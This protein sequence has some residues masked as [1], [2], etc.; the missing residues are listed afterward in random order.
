MAFEPTGDDIAAFFRGSPTLVEHRV[1]LPDARRRPEIRAQASLDARDRHIRTVPTD[2]LE[3]TGPPKRSA[4]GVAGRRDLSMLGDAPGHQHERAGG[5]REN[6]EPCRA[7][8]ELVPAATASSWNIRT[9]ASEKSSRSRPSE[10]SLRSRSGVSVMM[11]H[12]TLVGLDD[13]QHLRGLAQSNSKFA[14]AVR[15][16]PSLRAISGPGRRRRRRC[17]RRTPRHDGRRTARERIGRPRR[18]VRAS[19]ARWRSPTLLPRRVAP[20]MM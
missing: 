5:P 6:R 3:K 12:P 2:L 17:D 9:V 16:V 18:P 20:S 13:V 11:S 1:R 15:A 14:C 4:A 8:S 7:T 10:S 19:S